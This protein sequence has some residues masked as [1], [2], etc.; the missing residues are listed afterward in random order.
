MI[1][2]EYR[3]EIRQRGGDAWNAH[4]SGSGRAVRQ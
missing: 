2:D 4:V 1:E 3:T